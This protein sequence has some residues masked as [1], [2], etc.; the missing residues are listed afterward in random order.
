[1]SGPVGS[2]AGRGS[3]AAAGRGSGPVAG[4]GREMA[5]VVAACLAGAAGVW[6][7]ASRAWAVEV[8]DRPDPLPDIEVLRTGAQELPWLPALALVGLAGAGAV[9]ATRGTP[10]RLVGGL[11]AVVGM[12]LAGSGLAVLT[13]VLPLAGSA[14]AATSTPA[15]WPALAVLAAALLLAGGAVTAVRS[16]GWPAMGARYERPATA[17]RRGRPAE[18]TAA[19]DTVGSSATVGRRSTLDAWSAFDRGEDPTADDG[20]PSGRPKD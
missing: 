11:L 12:V 6:Y 2:A 13:G 17:A 15:G 3:G 9:L 16:G 20:P 1:M 5:G 14:T 4:A 19:A 8:T 7:S 18:P 10:R